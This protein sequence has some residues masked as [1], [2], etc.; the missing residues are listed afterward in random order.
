MILALGGL[1][2][3]VV[4][5]LRLRTKT[6][7]NR[8]NVAVGLVASAIGLVAGV[9]LTIT[10]LQADPRPKVIFVNNSEC[11]G[12]PV[13]LTK[14]NTSEVQRGTVQLGE[15]LEFPVEP[16]VVYRYSVDFSAAPRQTENWKCTDIQEGTVRVPPGSSQTFTLASERIAPP[17]LR[18]VTAT[19]VNVVP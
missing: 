13:T 16:D 18:P 8:Q 11:G 1:F 2:G 17:P 9:V 12:I 7:N 14:Q 10:S 4:L 19:P 6:Y 5:L 15:R 3:V